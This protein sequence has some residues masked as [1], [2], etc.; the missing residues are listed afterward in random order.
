MVDGDDDGNSGG[1]MLCNTFGFS[2][3]KY[4]GATVGPADGSA[5]KIT[6]GLEDGNIDG[7]PGGGRR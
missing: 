2:D 7:R 1:I 6:E 5:E 4:E 3:G